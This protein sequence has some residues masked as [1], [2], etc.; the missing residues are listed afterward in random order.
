[1]IRIPKLKNIEALVCTLFYICIAVFQLY[2]SKI[3]DLFPLHILNG[4]FHWNI[5]VS[6]THLALISFVP[7]CIFLVMMLVLN[8]FWILQQLFSVFSLIL[9]VIGMVLLC[10]TVDKW[11][12]RRGAGRVGGGFIGICFYLC[13]I[14][15]VTGIYLS[16]LRQQNVFDFTRGLAVAAVASFISVSYTHL[17]VYKRQLLRQKMT[18]KQKQKKQRQS[19]KF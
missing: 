15:L 5:A 2:I 7:M 1:M 10:S 8:K 4:A 6:Y 19:D 16:G 12:G 14:A 11:H 3:R 13:G 17:D 18:V 9:M